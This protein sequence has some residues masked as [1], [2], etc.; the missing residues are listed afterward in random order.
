MKTKCYDL[1][2]IRLSGAQ[3]TL[4]SSKPCQ[5]CCVTIRACPFLR[6]V[7]YIDDQ[8]NMICE[9]ASGIESNHLSHCQHEALQSGIVT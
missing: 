3:G 9:K 2:V 6:K 1:L 8:G 4:R 7:Y 5:Q